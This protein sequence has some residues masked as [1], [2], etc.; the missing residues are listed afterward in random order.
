MILQVA[1]FAMFISAS[2]NEES[3]KTT[4]DRLTNNRLHSIIQSQVQQKSRSLLLSG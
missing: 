4:I 2:L 1:Q 3:N